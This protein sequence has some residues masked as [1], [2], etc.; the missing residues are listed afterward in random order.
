M[1]CLQFISSAPRDLRDSE[2]QIL[3]ACP[4]AEEILNDPS[5]D[6]NHQIWHVSALIGVVEIV[7]CIEYNPRSAADR[8]RLLARC[9][10]LGV[11]SIS[12]GDNAILAFTEGPYCWLV[13]NANEF[14]AQSPHEGAL[15]LWTLTPQ[16]RQA[17]GVAMEVAGHGKG[18][19][20]RVPRCQFIQR[21]ILEGVSR[22]LRGEPLDAAI[23]PVKRGGLPLD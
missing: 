8:K 11:R 17:I 19:R 1:A 7:D 21:V 23:G 9:R 10:E 12:K 5:I 20:P 13:R 6:D 18:R 4:D 14:T 2:S 15:N 16:Q 22:P 3:A